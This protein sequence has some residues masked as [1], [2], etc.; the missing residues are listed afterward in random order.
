MS[1]KKSTTVLV[2]IFKPERGS[3]ETGGYSV[4][5]LPLFSTKM[6]W[7]PPIFAETT[8]VLDFLVHQ[9]CPLYR[10]SEPFM[11]ICNKKWNECIENNLDFIS[12]TY[13]YEY[14]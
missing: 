5:E 8:Y 9:D 7:M 1:K 2:E 12:F 13:K 11:E 4:A 10:I 14:D 3:F 6:K